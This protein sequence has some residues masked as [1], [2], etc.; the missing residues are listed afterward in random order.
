MSSPFCTV[1]GTKLHG[2]KAQIFKY[3]EEYTI[4]NNYFINSGN[5]ISKN[6]NSPLEIQKIY[7]LHSTLMP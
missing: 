5:F 6:K 2:H 1:M 3:F 4:Y 7:A